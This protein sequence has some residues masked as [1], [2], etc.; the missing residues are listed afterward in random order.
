MKLKKISKSHK[1]GKFTFGK[2]VKS[3]TIQK[4]LTFQ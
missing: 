2:V 4:G 3:N 1:Y